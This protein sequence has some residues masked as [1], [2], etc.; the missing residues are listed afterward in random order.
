MRTTED[1]LAWQ[2][3]GP[4]VV[5]IVGING[6]NHLHCQV[7]QALQDLGKKVM[8][9]EG[10]T[11][12]AAATQQLTV[13]SERGCRYRQAHGADAVAV[14]FH[15]QPQPGPG[16]GRGDDRYRRTPAQSRRPDA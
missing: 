9:A 15:A 4:T 11:Y 10:D 8:L 3:D 7:G 12:C 5:L 14:A 1:E 6:R 16:Y 2:S 13:W